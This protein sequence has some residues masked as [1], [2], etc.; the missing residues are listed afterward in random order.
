MVL[1]SLLLLSMVS[2][3]LGWDMIRPKNYTP[4]DKRIQS[5]YTDGVASVGLGAHISS[6]T[7]DE[8]TAGDFLW[9]NIVATA[10]TRKI[11]EYHARSDYYSWHNVTNSVGLTGDDQVVLLDIPYPMRARFY[12]GPGS[13]EY[14]AVWVCSNG[15]IRLYDPNASEPYPYRYYSNSIPDE[16]EPNAFI[17][18]FW[19][20]LKPNEG[21]SIT[22]GIVLHWPGFGGYIQCFCISWN[23][24]P[25]KD[26][27]L[28]TFQVLIEN[29]AETQYPTLQSRIW[30]QYESVTL[31]DQTTVGIEDQQGAKGNSYNYEELADGMTLLFE[32]YS[33]SALIYRLRIKISKNDPDADI[34]VVWD[35]DDPFWVRGYNVILTEEAQ[36]DESMRFGTAVGGTA[37]LL[38][39]AF[40]PVGWVAAAGFMLGTCLVG[41]SWADVLAHS[42]PAPVKDPQVMDHQDESYV[43]VRAV[44]DPD[45]IFIS[46][47]VDAALGIGVFWKFSDPN[48][49]K[50]HSITVT[51]ELDYFE[52]DAYGIVVSTETISTDNEISVKA[53]QDEAGDDFPEATY[54]AVSE[55][56]TTYTGYS[57]G[58][59]DPADW[60]KFHVDS[61]DR[62]TVSIT[63]TE[64]FRAELWSPTYERKAGP[65]TGI[66]Y[67]LSPS[68]PAGDWR[69]NVTMKELDEYEYGEIRQYSFD[70]RVRE[71]VDFKVLTFRTPDT[72]GSQIVGI[73]VTIN[74]QRYESPVVL[75]VAKGIYTVTVDHKYYRPYSEFTFKYWEDGSTN[76][77]RTVNVNDDTTITAY[78]Y[79]KRYG[80]C[81]TL[82]VWNGT[83][84]AEEGILDIH[85]ESDV[86]V[87]HVIQNALAYGVYKL[88][89]RELDNFTS[90]IDQVKLYAVDDEG[91]WHNCP[92]IYARHSELG[93]VTWKL[94]FD[95][96][97]RIDLTPTQTVNLKFLPAIYGETAYFIFEINGYNSK[98]VPR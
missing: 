75:A 53:L 21:G 52:Y 62:I 61:E 3:V 74:G 98:P 27:N 79:E 13:G 32:Q 88:Q 84:Y 7:E 80:S 44:E 96:E 24:V 69:I 57:D 64:Y 22:Y 92:L 30:F 38:I 36:P 6:Y 97:N 16:E 35:V 25:D 11:I 65:A 17:A 14:S 89:L 70:I 78:Y 91:E 10:N 58:I 72:G 59:G 49:D 46:N 54:I 56:T 9:L 47:A 48:D 39:S 51:A 85:A 5:S 93:K 82:F 95:D 43:V 20:D 33:N 76:P 71:T 42:M 41:L 23:N 2:G 68:D 18:P 12:G 50:D 81:P 29:G 63:P 8:P 66:D 73:G 86:T 45:E 1:I 15:W 34:D 83:H 67:T 4:I 87:Q 94:L 77:T 55:S 90:H 28:Q 19:R 60:Y 26:G 31:S 37:T 40:S